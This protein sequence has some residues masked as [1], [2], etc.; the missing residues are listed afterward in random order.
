MARTVYRICKASLVIQLVKNLPARREAQVRSLGRE[1]LLEKGMAT[2]PVFLA[3]KSHG[4]RGLAGY[5]P[6]GQ[7]ESDTTKR[8]THR[9]QNENARRLF[10][11]D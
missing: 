7:K 3:G 10:Q 5:S 1:D 2:T 4:P 8:L 9:V 6:W 11:N